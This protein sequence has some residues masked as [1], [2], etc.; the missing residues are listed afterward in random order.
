MRRSLVVVGLLGLVG[1][2]DLN[3]PQARIAQPGVVRATVLTAE[4]GKNE[5]VPARGATLTL[6]GTTQQATADQDGSVTLSGIHATT[7]RLLFG[8]GNSRSRILSLEAVGAGFG[9]DVNL[10]QVILG[11]NATLIGR[12][13]REDRAQLNS[14][15]GGIVAFLP[16]LPQLTVSGDDG[17]YRLS[18]VPEGDLVLSFSTPGYEAAATSVHV[19]PGEELR[20]DTVTLVANPGGAPVG[21]LS[22]LVQ[23][24][25]GTPI[26]AVTVRAFSRGVETVT[27]TSSEGRF[28]FGSIDTGVYALGFEKSGLSPLRVDGVL[29][30]PGVN[31]VGPFVMT[32]GSGMLGSLDGGGMPIEVDAGKPDD[33]GGKPDDDA[34]TDAGVD[35]GTSTDAGGSD[36]GGSTD[37]GTSDAGLDAGTPDAGTPDAGFDAGS[38]PLP[39]AIVTAFQNAAPNSQVT[40]NGTASTGSQPLIYTWTQLTDAGVTLNVNGTATAHSP[41]FTAPALGTVLDWSLVVTDRFGRASTNTAIT[42]VGIGSIPVAR[43]VPDAGTFLGGDLLALTSTSFDDGGLLL[44]TFDWQQ[45]PVVS[46]ATLIPNGNT[47]SLSLPQLMMGDQPVVVGVELRVINSIG[48]QSPV[49]RQSYVAQP[50]SGT[51]WALSAAL[52]G[53]SPILFNGA[54]PPARINSSVTTAVQSP[55]VSYSWSCPGLGSALTP[56]SGGAVEFAVP[57]VVG[58][59][60]IVSCTVTATGQPPLNPP[61]LQTSVGLTIRDD[62]NPSLVEMRPS[63]MVVRSSPLGVYVRASEPASVNNANN[64]ACSATPV[65]GAGTATILFIYGFFSA[66]TCGALSVNVVDRATVANSVTVPVV[67]NFNINHQW[68]GPFVSTSDFADPRPV[69]VSAGQLPFD[70]QR[71]SPPP[72]PPLPFEL[73][74][75]EGAS[76]VTFGVNFLGAPT[77]CNPTCPLSDQRTTLGLDP[78]VPTPLGERVANAGHELFVAMQR[79]QDAGMLDTLY[80]RRSADGTWTTLQAQGELANSGAEVRRMRL[81]NGAL[82]SDVFDPATSTFITPETV[83]ADAGTDVANVFSSEAHL[84]RLGQVAVFRTGGAIES[85]RRNAMLATWERLSHHQPSGALYGRTFYNSDTGGLTAFGFVVRSLPDHMMGFDGSPRP[86]NT[87]GPVTGGYDFVQRGDF[88]LLAVSQNGDLRLYAGRASGMSFVPGPPRVVPLAPGDQ[89]FDNDVSCE[90]AWPRVALMEDALV[91]TWQERCSPS[92]RWQVITRVLR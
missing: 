86:I 27:Q 57:N 74:A 79:A 1:C 4:P 65:E 76:L 60:R 28:V 69:V 25:D 81:Q 66:S 61:T 41:R 12:V 80:A 62:V 52:V 56:L 49:F 87:L 58:P 31:E 78:A 68:E 17:T 82:I 71:V 53:T 37:A 54:N 48:A 59:D 44:T 40:L 38:D 30:S 14:G 45:T 18:G 21:Q 85:Y 34:G 55:N 26:A 83:I 42:R 92:T 89:R 88:Q 10:G 15:H 11:R 72:S 9:K 64:G 13:L 16:Q 47:A 51:N 8:L 19:G 6:L 7:G 43:F 84:V 91:L 2:R 36:A 23:Q 39:F 63:S 46:G 90:A 29:V 67:P 35:A 75:R 20:I 5:L 33:D 24:P 77:T 50:G 3:L 70:L 73:V 22:G 32:A